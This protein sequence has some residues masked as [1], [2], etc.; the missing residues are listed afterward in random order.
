MSKVILNGTNGITG[1]E[2]DNVTVSLSQTISEL[3][4]LDNTTFLSSSVLKLDN[5]KVDAIPAPP[6]L[7]FADNN[8]ELV[9]IVLAFVEQA[10]SSTG[11]FVLA[12]APQAG[13]LLLFIGETWA[14]NY[15][16]ES[17]LLNGFIQIAYASHVWSSPFASSVRI[18]YKIATGTEGTSIT[19]RGAMP[20]QVDSLAV[21]SANASTVTLQDS[22]VNNNPVNTSF[23]LQSSQLPAI[24]I[25]GAVG[26]G[27]SN[28][29]ITNVTNN[30]FLDDT[31]YHSYAGAITESSSTSFTSSASSITGCTAA[32]LITVS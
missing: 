14:Y 3:N 27:G 25:I 5:L 28:S 12:A 24:A 19:V 11:T 15:Y 1:Y 20:S 8:F 26:Y 4:S 16:G 18:G 7:R 30:Y 6:L 31:G 17:N 9:P 21:Y 22:Y 29:N 23:S 10:S 32:A 13:D 2:A